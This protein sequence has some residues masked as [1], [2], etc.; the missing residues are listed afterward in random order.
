MQALTHVLAATD[1]SAP[2]RH[3]A[4]R[5]AMISATAACPLTLMHV[6]DVSVLERLRQ[7][8]AQAPEDL[9]QQVLD[10]A[11]LRLDELT[12]ALAQRHGVA[13]NASV[14]TG[15]ALSELAL[16]AQNLGD[17][18]MVCGAQ[19]ESFVRHVV[20]GSTAQRLLAK[21]A[22]PLL[23]VKQAPRAAYRRVLVPVDFSGWSLPA[24]R[25]AQ[26]VAPGADLVLMHAFTVPFEGKMRYASV[27]DDTIHQYR[28]AARLHAFEAL[29]LLRQQ[30]GLSATATQLLVLHGDPTLR[31]IE[32]EQ[33]QDCDLIVMGKHGEGLLESWLLGSVTKRVLGDCSADVLVCMTGA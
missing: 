9:Q 4:E 26:R 11:R 2:A 1:L 15:V 32:Q 10:T 25:A 18:L 13:I 21:V 28:V 29:S 6:A 24:I 14:R 31:V 3:A 19:G 27:D 22:C 30:A 20:L 16:A 7:L 12:R 8:V 5:A 33:E 17:G 23:V